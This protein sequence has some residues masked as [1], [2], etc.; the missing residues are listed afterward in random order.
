MT[1]LRA[2][3]LVL[4]SG[5]AVSCASQ[6]PGA[7]EI[8]P[9]R[10]IGGPPVIPTTNPPANPPPPTDGGT[11]PPPTDGG[12]VAGSVVFGTTFV[13]GNG[14]VERLQTVHMGNGGPQTIDAA[15]T[16][17]CLGC[18]GTAGAAMNKFLAAGVASE[19]NAEVGVKLSNGTLRTTR[20]G[21]APDT[22]FTIDLVAGDNI[23]GARTG[24]RNAARFKDMATPLT[25]GGCNQ[26]ACHG[27]T[28]GVIFKP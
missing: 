25:S 1:T 4:V 11:P 10:T 14:G 8:V 7:Y 18:H 26:G 5:L 23:A 13:A 21:A 24:V 17:D 27:G 3:P 9:R 20:S 12:T 19:A 28:Q 2:L 6:D 22:I 15:R 16:S